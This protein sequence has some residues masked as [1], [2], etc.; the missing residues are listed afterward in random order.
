MILF[1]CY[2]FS[3]YKLILLT[4]EDLS[5]GVKMDFSMQT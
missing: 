3:V 2:F 4:H 5:F 1:F